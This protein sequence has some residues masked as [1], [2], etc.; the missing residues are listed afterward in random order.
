MDD[1]GRRTRPIWRLP[2]VEFDLSGM[3]LG[4]VAYY[5]FA[6]L[7][8]PLASLLRT[9]S[10][11]QLPEGAK[12]QIAD[13][14]AL[15]TEFLG[16]FLAPILP[17]SDR[18]A[19]W[20]GW[21]LAV[22]AQDPEGQVVTKVLREIPYLQ[23]PWWHFLVV[24]AVLLVFWSILG[25]ALHRVHAVRIA[26]DETVH[27]LDAVS[28]ALSNLRSFL[29]APVFVLGAALLFAVATAAA[30]SAS[31]IPYAGPV[32]QI[33]L[34]PLALLS[35]LVLTVI[36]VGLVFGLPMT[37][38]AL[39]VE[40]NGF[41]DAVSRT[42]SYVFTRP[43]MFILS[44]VAVGFA[45]GILGT[46]GDWFLERASFV[47]GSG[48]LLVGKDSADAI[49]AGI[50]A[51]LRLDSP[52]EGGFAAWVACAVVGLAKLCV[53]GAVLSYV[54]GGLTDIYFMLR[55]E[56]DGIEDAEVYL[57][58]EDAS[59]GDPLPDE[60]TEPTEPA[61]QAASEAAPTTP[62]AAVDDETDDLPKD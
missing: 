26:R 13:A 58:D 6:V 29:S 50:N 30:G 53:K 36:M 52:A 3:M 33:I 5:V 51:G 42:F 28:F 11:Y 41:L 35:G 37:H 2:R 39:A 25:G 48:A 10:H 59:F 22:K 55:G 4:A 57:E 16:H 43:L 7:W 20:L 12:A 32:L 14:V 45:G 61:P 62:P 60:P 40:R 19:S 56:V 15:R 8:G 23:M 9:S 18:I 1:P 21:P 49:A 47:F 27:P 54:V 44:V 24:A 46:F 31:A 38:S 17:Y 34:Q